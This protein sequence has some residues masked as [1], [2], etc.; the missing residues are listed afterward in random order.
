M[1]QIH[2]S[3][4]F[5]LGPGDQVTVSYSLPNKKWRSGI[6]L[7]PKVEP[8]DNTIHGSIKNSIQSTRNGI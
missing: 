4:Q 1:G 6:S 7:L 8:K 2:L 5:V 3:D